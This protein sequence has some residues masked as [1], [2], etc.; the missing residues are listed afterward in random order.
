MK[1][2]DGHVADTDDTFTVH[3]PPGDICF[4][5]CYYGEADTALTGLSLLAYLGAG[6]THVDGKYADTVARGLNFLRQSQKPTATSGAPAGRSGC[7]ATPS[8]P[9]PSARPTP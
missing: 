7:T 9:W 8:R 3:C 6:Y 1:F 2:R 4:G 5:E